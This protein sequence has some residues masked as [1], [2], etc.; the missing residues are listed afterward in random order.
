MAAREYEKPEMDDFGSLTDVTEAQNFT[1]PE[2][3]GTKIEL[4]IP[5][6]SGPIVPGP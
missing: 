1:G 4:V 2:D 3:G 6:H 5:H